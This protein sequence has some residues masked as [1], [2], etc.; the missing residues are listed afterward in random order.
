MTSTKKI[1]IICGGSMLHTALQLNVRSKEKKMSREHRMRKNLKRVAVSATLQ[2]VEKLDELSQNM[3][4]D[5]SKTLSILLEEFV[6]NE[7]FRR[8]YFRFIE[9]L[10]KSGITEKGP[11]GMFRNYLI[12]TCILDNPLIAQAK[13]EMGFS[14][15]IRKFIYYCHHRKIAVSAIE[16]DEL[17]IK[18][19][20]AGIEILGHVQIDNVLSVQFDVSHLIKKGEG[21]FF[22]Q[23]AT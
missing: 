3:Q 18:I 23:Q 22:A 7:E 12:P 1:C 2:Y 16:I 13:H 15:F 9:K 10:E 17:L 5:F 14:Q 11:G 8:G 21:N 4:K 20:E 6:A 19:R